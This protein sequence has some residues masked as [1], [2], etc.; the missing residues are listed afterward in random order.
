MDFGD[1]HLWEEPPLQ[2][3]HGPD[4]HVLQPQLTCWQCGRPASED[5]TDPTGPGARL[6]ELARE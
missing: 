6:G 1:R 2:W 3:H 4:G 5:L